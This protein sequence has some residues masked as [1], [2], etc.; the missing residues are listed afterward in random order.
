MSS[1]SL[2]TSS[3]VYSCPH[4]L[5]KYKLNSNLQKH[6]GI[7]QFLQQTRKQLED[8][9][10]YTE[11]VPNMTELFH[12]VQ[13]LSLRI[14]KL[15]K[16]NSALKQ[17]QKKNLNIMVWLNEQKTNQPAV[18]FSEWITECLLPEIKTCMDILYEQDIYTSI[19]ALFRKVLGNKETRQPFC[20]F[21][22][23]KLTF[24]VYNKSA[25]TGKVDW[26][27]LDDDEFNRLV[28][29]LQAR[30]IKEFMNGW[31]AENEAL[32]LENEDLYTTYMS[33][34]E[35]ISKEDNVAKYRNCIYSAINT[36][37]KRVIEY[38]F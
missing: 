2:N 6:V 33:Y 14:D 26:G 16:E 13:Y 3:L 34:Y 22:K 15:E 28:K 12:I 18:L 32:I 9:A 20:A 5:R 27:R 37:I 38:E 29:R 36:P 10:E 21:D 23:K 11:K 30:Y 19:T 25:D 1:T 24:Y 4:C 8:T 31:Y 35:K 17:Q 7:C